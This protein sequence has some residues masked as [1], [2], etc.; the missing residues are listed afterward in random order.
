MRRIEISLLGKQSLV[1]NTEKRESSKTDKGGRWSRKKVGVR[2][3]GFG[4]ERFENV[5]SQKQQIMPKGLE[6]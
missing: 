4:K 3:S 1:R 5:H 6:K 2:G